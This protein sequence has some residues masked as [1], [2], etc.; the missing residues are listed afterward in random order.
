MARIGLDID[1]VVCQFAPIANQWLATRLGVPPQPVDKWNW[2]ENYGPDGPAAWKAFWWWVE[3]TNGGVFISL[4]PEPYALDAI[5]DLV[6]RGHEVCFITHR[7]PRY[8]HAMHTWLR[9]NKLDAADVFEVHCTKEKWS[10]DCD[11]YVDDRPD[12]VRDLM[13]HGKDAY[14]MLQP[15]NTKDW[16]EDNRLRALTNLVELVQKLHPTSPATA[17][18]VLH[19]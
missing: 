5:K 18:E 2:F 6:R 15:W 3:D 11:I 8:L 16:F 19:A 7:N 14:L 9:R 17:P 4:D 1:G 13:D 12:N 10:V